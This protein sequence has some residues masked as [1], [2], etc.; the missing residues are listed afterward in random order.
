M[1]SDILPNPG[2]RLWEE[3]NAQ[4]IRFNEREKEAFA[5]GK[6]AVLLE[7]ESRVRSSEAIGDV[8]DDESLKIGVVDALRDVQ[9]SV[10]SVLDANSVT[11]TSV[12]DWYEYLLRSSGASSSGVAPQG[13][14][15]RGQGIGRL[16]Q[17]RR[18]M[19]VPDA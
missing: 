2:A 14:A 1:E 8:L 16:D 19:D 11:D 7:L 5:L 10:E 3:L 6:L 9:K 15:P 17:A 13:T 18:M 4:G 12:F